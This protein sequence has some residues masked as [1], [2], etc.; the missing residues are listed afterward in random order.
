M[1][2]P[3]SSRAGV[4]AAG[5]KRDALGW[6][7]FWNDELRERRELELP[8]FSFLL[9]IKSPSQRLKESIMAKLEETGLVPMD[10][11]EPP[12]VFWVTVPSP[13]RVQNALAPF[14]FHRK[15]QDRFSR[16][17]RLDRLSPR[18]K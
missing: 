16:N 14:F 6:D 5:G 8:P 1:G 12:L 17:Y 7:H 15:L 9:E 11:G 13:S 10:P 18:R 3:S 2:A 4:R